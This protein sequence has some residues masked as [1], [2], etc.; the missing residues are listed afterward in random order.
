[1][2]S[3]ITQSQGISSLFTLGYLQIHFTNLAFASRTTKIHFK[4]TKS[5]PT[6]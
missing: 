4:I 1:M 5:Y 3:S 2:I 6:K